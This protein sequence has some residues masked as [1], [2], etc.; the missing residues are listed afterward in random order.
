MLS[1]SPKRIRYVVAAIIAAYL[2]MTPWTTLWDR[3]EPRFARAAVEMMRSGEFLYPTFGG[4]VRAQKP[5]LIYWLMALS[6]SLFGVSEFGARFWAPVAMG[7]T[8]AATCF[9]GRRLASPRAA[10]LAMLL[11]VLNPLAMM[12]GLAATADAVL[13]AL[14]TAALAAFVALLNRRGSWAALVLFTAASG[15]AMLTKGPVG[16][17]PLAVAAGTLWSLRRDAAAPGIAMPLAGAAAASVGLFLLWAVPA[18]LAT[19]GAFVARGVQHDIV[20]RIMV[21][22]EGHGG[23]PLVWLPFYPLV[24]LVGFAPWSACLPALARFWR[25]DATMGRTPRALLAWWMAVP[26]VA[27]SAAATHLPHYILPMWPALALGT[28]ILIDR[29]LDGALDARTAAWLRRGSAIAGLWTIAIAA[30]TVAGHV[31]FPASDLRASVLVVALA[32]AASATFIRFAQLP[33]RA[34]LLSATLCLVA[35]AHVALAAAWLPSLERE[36]PV[37]RLA[38]LIRAR[39]SAPFHLAT[40]G[41]GEPSLDFYAGVPAVPIRTPEEL[42]RWLEIPGPAVLVTTRA[43]Q[44]AAAALM[45]LREIASAHG[46]NIANGER[47]ELVALERSLR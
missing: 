25:H 35:A 40:V 10:V 43:L 22:L 14:V 24:V 1:V 41:F 13:L 4:E 37:P 15:A 44:P 36:K 20:N 26:M 47:I 5:I 45:P 30:G 33:S 32:A 18:N 28:G 2:A 19:G 31:L 27:F 6:M 16:L 29:A 21:P 39:V 42:R 11:V 8:A 46:V 7:A 38:T 23:N 9:I 17:M 3:D 12:Q 34:D